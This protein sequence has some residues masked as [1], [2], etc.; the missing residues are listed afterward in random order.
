MKNQLNIIAY[1]YFIVAL[2]TLCLSTILSI[3][4][5]ASHALGNCYYKSTVNRTEFSDTLFTNFKD[6]K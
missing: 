5:Q 3:L 1:T 6:I 4:V 2:K